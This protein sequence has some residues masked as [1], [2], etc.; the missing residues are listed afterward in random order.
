MNYD[1]RVVT[2]TEGAISH[3][4]FSVGS[5]LNFFPNDAIG[6]ANRNK[7]AERKVKIY[8]GA[9]NPV[10]SDIAGD[11]NFFR[12]RSWAKD[13]YDAHK[14]SGGDEVVVE[15]VSRYEYHIYPK[16]G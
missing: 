9:G 5:I 3:N 16:R 1:Y 8:W 6:G 7:S 13:F 4:Y 2:I 12:E 14:I 15:R 10:R 11:K